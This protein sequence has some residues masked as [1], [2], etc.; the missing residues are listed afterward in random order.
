MQL[1]SMVID[2]AIHNTDCQ[3]Q[4]I[5]LLEGVVHMPSSYD[6]CTIHHNIIILVHTLWL[7]WCIIYKY[8]V[9]VKG[10]HVLLTK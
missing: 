9:R 2:L 7:L 1:V 8:N 5:C 10:I 3:S 4:L 6:M